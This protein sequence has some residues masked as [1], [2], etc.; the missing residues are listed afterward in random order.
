LGIRWDDRRRRDDTRIEL[1]LP[2]VVLGRSGKVRLGRRR[3][4]PAT[5]DALEA[6]EARYGD[7]PPALAA[8]GGSFAHRV[9]A[10]HMGLVH[11][12][13][14]MLL[15]RFGRRCRPGDA[16]HGWLQLL[17]LPIGTIP[18]DQLPPLAQQNP[19]SQA[20]GTA[21]PESV[22]LPSDVRMEVFDEG[23]TMLRLSWGSAHGWLAHAL[24]ELGP[25]LPG[26]EVRVRWLGPLSEA[27]PY[28]RRYDHLTAR[29]DDGGDDAEAHVV[30]TRLLVEVRAQWNV[31]PSVARFRDW[32]INLADYL[33]SRMDYDTWRQYYLERVIDDLDWKIGRTTKGEEPGLAERMRRIDRRL[34][35]L[36]AH[37]WPEESPEGGS[38]GAWLSGHGEG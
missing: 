10:E 18:W 21:R 37:L 12:L 2:Y 25:L 15:I 6:W 4:Y 23:P 8:G 16:V 29:L 24:P 1:L 28:D 5:S 20:L 30:V 11:H 13:L 19:F 34:A 26:G 14:M 27:R 22:C 9:M 36:E 7:G 17:D 32:A 3:S 35:R 38:D 31:L 33:A